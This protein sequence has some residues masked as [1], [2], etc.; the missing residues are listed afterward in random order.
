MGICYESSIRIQVS[1][2][3]E[4]DESV[5]LLSLLLLLFCRIGMLMNAQSPWWCRSEV[6][7]EE[8]EIGVLSEIKDAEEMDP[9][10]DSNADE[11]GKDCGISISRSMGG[12][13]HARYWVTGLGEACM[14]W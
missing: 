4:G 13:K 5:V 8:L 12:G 6:C 7:R 1:G 2:S 11:G 10:K 3:E 9:Y 14:D